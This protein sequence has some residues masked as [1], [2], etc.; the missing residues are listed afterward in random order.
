LWSCI[1]TPLENIVL[2][3]Y[4]GYIHVQ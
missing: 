1:G 2:L 3:I 4:K